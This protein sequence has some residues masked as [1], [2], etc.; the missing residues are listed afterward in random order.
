MACLYSGC[1]EYVSVG[2]GFWPVT[3]FLVIDQHH[4]LWQ[5][6]SILYFYY[7]S[8]ERLKRRYLKD[9]RVS[10]LNNE[11]SSLSLSGLIQI[12]ST[13][14]RSNTFKIPWP[15]RNFFEMFARAD[16]GVITEPVTV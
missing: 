2:P 9:E 6:L 14:H 7:K 3:K 13:Q 10:L 11:N 4:E 8:R 15:F 1:L 5:P 16:T 12:A